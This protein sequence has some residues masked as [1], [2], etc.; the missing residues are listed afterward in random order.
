MLGGIYIHVQNLSQQVKHNK[1]N[2]PNLYVDL[3]FPLNF[4]THPPYPVNPPPPPFLLPPPPSTLPGYEEEVAEERNITH[5]TQ[6]NIKRT[7]PIPN[8]EILSHV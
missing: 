1:A 6:V 5:V 8:Y 7:S 2:F 4:L 3:S